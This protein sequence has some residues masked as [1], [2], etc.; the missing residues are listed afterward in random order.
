MKKLLCMLLSVLFIFTVMAPGLCLA[1][2]EEAFEPP[3]DIDEYSLTSSIAAS[4]SISGGTAQVA[5]RV[6]AQYASA[7]CSIKVTL[8]KKNSNGTWSAVKS[9]SKSGGSSVST[10]GSVSVSSGSYRTCV[11]ATIT[12]GSD[13][14]HPFVYS[15]TKTC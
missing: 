14:E 11:T 10:G 8:Q 6:G 2:E 12:R 7:S 1:A 5:G 13:S 3:V 9:W 15:G 4:L